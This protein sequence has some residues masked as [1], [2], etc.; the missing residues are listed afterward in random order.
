MDDIDLGGTFELDGNQSFGLGGSAG[1]IPGLAESDGSG[2]DQGSIGKPMSDRSLDPQEAAEPELDLEPDPE[3]SSIWNRVKKA[4]D[5]DDD[6]TNNLRPKNNATG[7]PQ[8]MSMM[9]GSAEMNAFSAS[10]R[11]ES[12]RN[13]AGAYFM[14]SNPQ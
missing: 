8:S 9:P 14:Q 4:F 3:S 6:D 10:I 11:Q 13:M 7:Q 5:Q 12:S 1:S 2:S